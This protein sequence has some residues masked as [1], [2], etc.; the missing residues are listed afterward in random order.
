MCSL[1]VEIYAVNIRKCTKVNQ[2]GNKLLLGACAFRTIAQVHLGR[3]QSS[4]TEHF[5]EIEKKLKAI[6]N[7]LQ[8]VQS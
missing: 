6:H 4:M 1:K 3:F 5:E 7:F 2:Q 8:I